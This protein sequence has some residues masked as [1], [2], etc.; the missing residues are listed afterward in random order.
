MG[1][2]VPDEIP[3]TCGE[4]C[5]AFLPTILIARI[6]V[7]GMEDF[8]GSVYNSDVDWCTFEGLLTG[9]FSDIPFTGIFC[10]TGNNDLQMATQGPIMAQCGGVIINE[11]HC[12]I[13]ASKVSA[14]GCTYSI[15]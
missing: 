7:P 10:A 12:S 8:V 6:Q 2:K 11:N 3:S 4:D 15:G 5:C 13:P 1:E 9:E 14:G